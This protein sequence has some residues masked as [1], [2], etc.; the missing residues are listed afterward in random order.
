MSKQLIYLTTFVLVLGLVGTTSAGVIVEHVGQNDPLTE[1]F[2]IAVGGDPDES[3][4]CA[5]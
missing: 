3:T 2:T 1:G 5:G 4:V